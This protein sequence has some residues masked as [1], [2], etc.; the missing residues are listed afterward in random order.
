MGYAGV[1]RAESNEVGK[2]GEKGEGGG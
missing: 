1:G 2:G